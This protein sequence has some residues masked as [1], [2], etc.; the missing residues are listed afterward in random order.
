[1]IVAGAVICLAIGGIAAYFYS[2]NANS[3]DDLRPKRAQHS[4]DGRH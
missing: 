4:S 2:H 1:M 3:I